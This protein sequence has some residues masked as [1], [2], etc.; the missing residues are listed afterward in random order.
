MKY[1][2]QGQKIGTP[3][4]FENFHDAIEGY[5]HEDGVRNVLRVDRYTIE[6]PPADGSRYAYVLDM[7]VESDNTRR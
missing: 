7:V 5:E 4:A 6:N 2:D 1:D 3:E